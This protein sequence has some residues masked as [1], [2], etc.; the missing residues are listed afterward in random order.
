MVI[1][2]YQF[3][4]LHLFFIIKNILK[5]HLKGN[6]NLNGFLGEQRMQKVWFWTTLGSPKVTS[7]GPG[8]MKM[9]AIE[10]SEGSRL[11][12][13]G[14]SKCTLL[15]GQGGV[16]VEGAPLAPRQRQ[17]PQ[18]DRTVPAQSRSIAVPIVRGRLRRMFRRL[19]PGRRFPRLRFAQ[20]RFLRRRERDPHSREGMVRGVGSER[21]DA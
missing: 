5:K 17:A 3:K 11:A 9:H 12:L 2:C 14:G 1:N 6:A 21:V 19:L 20:R 13:P 10:R 15:G 4:L 18:S 8:C 7:F 16:G